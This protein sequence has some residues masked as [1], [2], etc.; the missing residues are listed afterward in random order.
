MFFQMPSKREIHV[1]LDCV[2][3]IGQISN[4]GH[5]DVVWGSAMQRWEYGL[6]PST[7]I[8]AISQQ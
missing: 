5:Q 6:R 7:G 2:A 3:V 4:A 1:E 8:I